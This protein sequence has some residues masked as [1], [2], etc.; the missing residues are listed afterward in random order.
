MGRCWKPSGIFRG[1]PRFPISD[2]GLKRQA[3]VLEG[4]RENGAYRLAGP[5]TKSKRYLSAV[6]M[7]RRLRCV[8]QPGA[9]RLGIGRKPAGQP[10][11]GM[12]MTASASKKKAIISMYIR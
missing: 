6:S 9:G 7:P 5:A 1:V 12:A 11:A 4:H 2:G 8:N 3:P 10:I